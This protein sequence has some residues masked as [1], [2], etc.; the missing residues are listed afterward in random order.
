[1][2]F[3]RLIFVKQFCWFDTRWRSS[4]CI[5]TGTVGDLFPVPESKTAS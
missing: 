3:Y 5:H 2:L 4:L 1:M